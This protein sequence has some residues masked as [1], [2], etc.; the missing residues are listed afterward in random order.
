VCEGKAQSLALTIASFSLTCP[1]AFSAAI[2]CTSL[3]LALRDNLYA[4]RASEAVD[5]DIE[6]LSAFIT[7]AS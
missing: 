7:D 1:V 2:I 4:P 5:E 6:R 3:Y